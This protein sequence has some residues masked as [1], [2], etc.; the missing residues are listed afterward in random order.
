M[1]GYAQRR[2]ALG[3]IISVAGVGMTV[4]AGVQHQGRQIMARFVALALLGLWMA[5]SARRQAKRPVSR[6]WG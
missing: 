3:V 5:L 4:V 1:N 6:W 2:I